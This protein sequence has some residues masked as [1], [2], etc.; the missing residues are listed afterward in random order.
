MHVHVV[1]RDESVHRVLVSDGCIGEMAWHAADNAI[2]H[3]EALFGDSTQILEG[4]RSC[5]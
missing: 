5:H 3:A 1:N 2:G 4:S